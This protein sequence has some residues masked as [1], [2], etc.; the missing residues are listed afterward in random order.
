MSHRLRLWFGALV[1]GLFV[2]G[3]A[4][5]DP[6]PADYSGT[7]HGDVMSL[8]VTILGAGVNAALAH[9]A[10]TVDSTADPRAHAES[11]NMEAGAIGIT[12][13]VASGSADSDNTTLTDSYSAGFPPLTAAPILSTGVLTGSGS[14][15]WAGDAAC[16]PDGTPI[17][18]STTSMA[19]ASV[20]GI[21]GLNILSM[22]AASTSGETTLQGGSVVSTSSGELAGLSLMNGLVQVNVATQPT[23]TATSDGTTGSVTANAYAVAVTVGGVT[24]TLT[25][26]GSLPISLSIPGVA[27]ISLTIAVG[28]LTNT[29]SGATGSGSLELLSITG[30]IRQPLFGTL[31]ASLDFGLMSLSATATAPAGGVECDQLDAPAITSPTTGGTTG[32]TPTISGTGVPGATVTVTD[33]T[34][35]VLGTAVVDA[36]G[37]WSLTPDAPL[38]LGDHTITATQTF[39]PATSAPSAPVSFTVVDTTPPTTPV[40]TSPES[41]TITSDTTPTITGTGEPGATVT[42][43]DQDGNVLGTA[44]VDANGDW[45]LTPAPLADGDYTIT[46]TQ[47]DVDGNVSPESSAVIFT[48]DTTAP[49]A[50][51]VTGPSDGA[52]VGTATPTITGTGEPGATVEVVVDG[53]VVG[54]TVVGSDGSW[55]LELT[56]PLA[57][58]AHTVTAT[59][60]DA[61]GNES[62]AS[63]PT[64]FTVD[65]VAEPPVITSP[66]PGA[67]TSD[68]TP[69]ITGT[70]EPGATVTVTDQTGTVLG[71][72]VVD[73]NG[74]WSLTPTTPLADGDYTI[75]A[76]QVDTQGNA[77][78]E[79]SPVI[80]T[81][82][83]TAPAAPVITGPA[84]GSTVGTA[85]PTI[86]GTGEPGATVEVVVDGTVVGTTVVGSD[87]SWTLALTTPL[88]DGEHTVTATQTDVAGNESP[89]S[90]PTTFTVDTTPLAPV[91]TSPGSGT[92]TSDTTPTI[93]GTG[94]P[95]ATVTVTDQTGTVLGTAL[96]DLLGNWSLTPTTP[97]ADG[98]Y[99]ITATQTDLLGNTSGDSAAVIFTVDTTAPAAPVVTGP[100]DGA[101]VGTATPTITGTGEPGATVEVVIDG[102]VVGTTVVGPDGTWA[103]PLTTPLA[104]G[105]HTVTA[106][107]TDAAGNESPASAPTTFTVDT[108]ATAPVITS[109]SPGAITSDTTPTITGT[110]E[111]GATVTVTDQ[112]GTVLGTAVVDANGDWSLTPTTPLPDGT[113]TITATQVDTQ[114]NVST[115]SGAVIFTID[116]TAPAAPVITGPGD[117]STVGTSTPAITGTGEPGATVEV[118]IDGET[119]GTVVVGPTGTWTLPL[120]EPLAEGEHTVIAIETDEAGNVSG[121]SAPVNF[122]VD[123][124]VEQRPRP[125]RESPPAVE[126]R[127]GAFDLAVEKRAS[128]RRVKVGQPITYRI[129]VRNIGAAAAPDVILTDTVNA[130]VR[131]V[132]VRTSQGSCRRGNPLRCSL[133]RIPAGGS[134]TIRAVVRHRE[135]GRRQ[136]NVASATG[137]GTDANRA[138]NRDAVSVRV[139]KIRLRVS[140]LASAA[141]VSSGQSFGY[142]IRVRNPSR[143]VARRVRVCD[144]LPAAVVYVSSTPRVRPR[145]GRLCWT[146]GRLGPGESRSFRV[147]VRA[148]NGVAASPIVNRVT[149]R[150]PDIFAVGDLSHVR[151]QG[152]PP[153]VT[154]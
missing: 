64:T 69:T 6:L 124:V 78:L 30:E 129:V 135:P 107:Q 154:G 120:S 132:A 130:R 140:K 21:A 106:T 143:G 35:T 108:V 3:V 138:N 71:T 84:D 16:V 40:I 87:G 34:G 5:A 146:I 86:T 26:G 121:P 82:D 29:S 112:D 46:A 20:G 68:T 136:R 100:S 32:P 97:L 93:T 149:V 99:T 131:V 43:T 13:P 12:V 41:G 137:N 22:G 47:V 19:S 24:T 15:T 54:T 102:A 65:T 85:T 62:P 118:V 111:P 113:Y 95:G 27:T 147:R 51:V 42:V 1:V 139:S 7:T 127:P 28:Q 76:T 74:E 4:Q 11:A 63:A 128:A 92:I 55:T 75:T 116:T 134:V 48:V 52:T 44:V 96:V 144:R 59:Q 70:G 80:F 105:E 25:A 61:A 98:T 152:A 89:A 53:V 66:S 151:M 17:A 117:D 103:L 9:S 104:D 123:T 49:A 45:S 142:R 101:M 145:A 18:E 79:S 60:T 67:I 39:G 14:T 58:G 94:I 153:P 2:P 56:E 133:G 31:L 109:P 148:G 150:S 72:A 50:P 119:V 90:A 91:I 73:A 126:E 8:N 23:I 36:N 114:G 37:N 110:G 88:A 115:E 33:Q 122:I 125:P 81:V 10:T 141:V 77:S 38:A 83:S 57:D